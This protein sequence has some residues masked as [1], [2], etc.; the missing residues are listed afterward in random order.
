M[1]SFITRW[2]ISV[3][4][5]SRGISAVAAK[6]KVSTYVRSVIF[7]AVFAASDWL[8]PVLGGVLGMLVSFA[9]GYALSA[10]C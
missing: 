4:S 3:M 2:S 8:F 6:R 7:P 1:S 5:L 9:I 10:E